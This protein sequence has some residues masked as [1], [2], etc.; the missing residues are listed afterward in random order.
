VTCPWV[1]PAMPGTAAGVSWG[2][3]LG[4]PSWPL[5]L[6]PQASSVPSDSTA[7][8]SNL[9]ADTCVAPVRAICTGAARAVSVPSPTPPAQ[10][11]PQPQT[12]PM[13]PVIAYVKFP[14]VDICLTSDSDGTGTGLSRLVLVPSPSASLELSPQA[15]S[16]PSERMARADLPPAA[17][18]VIP[19]RLGCC[20]G[21]SELVV[22]P[23][24]SS[25]DELS[26]Q[27]QTLPS[28]RSA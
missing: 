12:W 22:V 6:D 5:R 8:P 17:T 14:L 1:T 24:P 20:P 21:S 26:P 15:A 2:C 27:S 18:W 9:P 11:K 10:L 19:V 28:E 25:P 3:G 13:L 16:V 4:F 23:L 7:A